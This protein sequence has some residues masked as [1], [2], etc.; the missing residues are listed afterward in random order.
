MQFIADLLK[1]NVRNIGI[2][3]VSALGAAYMAG[4]AA[5]LFKDLASLKEINHIQRRYIPGDKREK[6]QKYYQGW[7]EALKMVP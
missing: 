7:R 6:V 1:T 5:E 3:D 2:A 4:L